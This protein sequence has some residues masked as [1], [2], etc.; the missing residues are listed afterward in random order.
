MQNLSPKQE[1]ILRFIRS[2]IASLGYAPT[3]REIADHM[4]IGSTN[5]VND[6]LRA[7]ERKGHIR[8]VTGTCRAITLVEL[9]HSTPQAPLEAK[10]RV[11]LSRYQIVAVEGER[12]VTDLA[13]ELAAAVTEMGHA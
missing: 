2:Q 7:I 3:F 6:H 5:A 4:G 8:R 1:I 12:V 13:A 11:A 10:L 9:D